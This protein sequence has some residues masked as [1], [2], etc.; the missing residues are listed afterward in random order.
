MVFRPSCFQYKAILNKSDRK[1]MVFNLNLR[2]V[3][4]YV[5]LLSRFR[6]EFNVKIH[7]I[8]AVVCYIFLTTKLGFLVSYCADPN[9]I[10][11]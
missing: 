7:W 5:D 1:T 3:D 10:F 8:R 6:S 4:Q 9:E 2:E 11:L